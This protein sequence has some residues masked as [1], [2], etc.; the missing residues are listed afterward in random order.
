MGL[1]G[2][3]HGIGIGQRADVPNRRGG[4]WGHDTCTAAWTS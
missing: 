2:T 3:S 1:E 4:E